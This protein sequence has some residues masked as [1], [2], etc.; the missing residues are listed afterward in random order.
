MRIVIDTSA[1]ISV[2]TNEP[3]RTAILRATQGAELLAPASLHWEVGNAFSAMMRR[4]RI[5]RSSAV[6]AVNAYLRIPLRLTEVD[7]GASLGIA[8]ATGLCAYDAY[9]LECARAH[10]APLLTLDTTLKQ[11]AIN[12]GIPILEVEA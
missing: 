6:H 8:E 7:L 12:L 3:H 5:H 11:A 2:I 10:R 1:V 9:V 4:G